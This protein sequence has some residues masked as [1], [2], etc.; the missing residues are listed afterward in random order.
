MEREP[1]E[2]I[3]PSIPKDLEILKELNDG[4]DQD[5]DHGER[6]NQI[7]LR[8]GDRKDGCRGIEGI[9]QMES[10]PNHHHGEKNDQDPF[11]RL[12]TFSEIMS[13]FGDSLGASFQGP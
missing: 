6:E 3:F 4:Q 11:D 7:E 9:D 2:I 12:K 5:Q 10:L 8:E 1:C 13:P